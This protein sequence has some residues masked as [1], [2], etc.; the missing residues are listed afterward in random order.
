MRSLHLS[1]SPT[2]VHESWNSIPPEWQGTNPP[3]SPVTRVWHSSSLLIF[4][5]VFNY[6]ILVV[7]TGH[8]PFFQKMTDSVTL[9]CFVQLKFLPRPFFSYAPMSVDAY[10]LS[11]L[12]FMSCSAP[13]LFA[14]CDYLLLIP[15]WTCEHGF[16]LLLLPLMWH[17]Y[18]TCCFL[19]ERYKEQ[20]L[21]DGVCI[22][23]QQM[24]LCLSTALFHVFMH[25]QHHSSRT[26]A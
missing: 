20:R 1:P 10:F 6:L 23:V 19:W 2:C 5:C 18:V 26:K 4:F 3:S 15:K 11:V 22:L 13:D 21:L 25:E 24:Y 17:V 8:H 14:V 9:L 7:I 12:L 16:F